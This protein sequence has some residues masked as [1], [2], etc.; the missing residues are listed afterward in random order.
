MK[1]SG[2][3][4]A[5]TSFLYFKKKMEEKGTDLMAAGKSASFFTPSSSF[6][7]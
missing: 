1:W 5:R 2:L 4:K 7:V 3:L 6:A